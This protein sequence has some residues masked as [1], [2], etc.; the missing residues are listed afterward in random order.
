MINQGLCTELVQS[1]LNSLNLMNAIVLRDTKQ[2][3][4]KQTITSLKAKRADICRIK[5]TKIICWTMFLFLL[6]WT[7]P[8]KLCL[9]RG[10]MIILCNH[11]ER[12]WTTWLFFALN[13]LEYLT[14]WSSNSLLCR[15]EVIGVWP[16]ILCF[17]NKFAELWRHYQYAT[18]HFK[19][20][21]V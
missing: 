10:L 17:A 21:I 19:M 7:N 13:V 6:I 15:C 2:V 14:L 5:R 4:I 3:R 1:A 8:I 12:W 9:Q 16:R 20:K 11:F 18:Y